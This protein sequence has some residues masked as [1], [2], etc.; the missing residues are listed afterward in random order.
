MFVPCLDFDPPEQGAPASNRPARQPRWA[1]AQVLSAPVAER[2]VA[3][4]NADTSSFL[5]TYDVPETGAWWRGMPELSWMASSHNPMPRCVDTLLPMMVH[6]VL[7]AAPVNV[8]A[9]VIDQLVLRIA[10]R[11]RGWSPAHSA[12]LEAV[13]VRRA[14]RLARGR[15]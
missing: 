13:F 2:S 7:A 11:Q 5:A 12:T 3:N 9:S 14:G 4:S 10:L 6:G 8:A 15:V 1:L